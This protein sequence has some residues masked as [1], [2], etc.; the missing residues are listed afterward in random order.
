MTAVAFVRVPRF[1]RKYQKPAGVPCLEHALNLDFGFA[2]N[3]TGQIYASRFHGTIGEDS[4]S[5]KTS[6]AT[7][8]EFV[9]VL[10]NFTGRILN[11]CIMYA[12]LFRRRT[13]AYIL[14][15]TVVSRYHVRQLNIICTYC[16]IYSSAPP[17][18]GR[19]AKKKK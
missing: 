18:V 9:N 6:A 17:F 1:P 16:C 19:I 14:H 4:V 7:S 2:M 15:T 5:R 3:G 8:Q 12:R 11:K 10:H 13:D